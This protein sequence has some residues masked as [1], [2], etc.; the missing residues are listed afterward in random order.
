MH[1]GS[2]TPDL[3]IL[4]QFA[5]S[6]EMYINQPD[7]NSGILSEL[8]PFSLRRR[9]RC[10]HFGLYIVMSFSYSFKRTWEFCNISKSNSKKQK[11][12]F[13]VTTE[14]NDT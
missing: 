2:A 10:Y 14:C 8:N 11:M 6:K 13:Y 3:D 9:Q 12:P 7:Q 4:K 5:I 1:S